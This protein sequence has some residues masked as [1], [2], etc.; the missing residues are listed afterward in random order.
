ML[1]DKIQR[2]YF[3]RRY[4][5][6]ITLFYNISSLSLTND[7]HITIK[8]CWVFGDLINLQHN[9]ERLISVSRLQMRVTE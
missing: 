2:S 6:L 8:D 4:S 1:Y 5:L 3:L 9:D 7:T